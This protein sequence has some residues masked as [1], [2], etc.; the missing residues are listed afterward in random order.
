MCAALT[1]ISEVL[2]LS[3][4]VG[5]SFL[6][7][8]KDQIVSFWPHTWVPCC[9]VTQSCLTLCNPMAC[10]MPGFCVLHH[11][12]EF[13][14]THIYWVNDAIQLS[15]PV[16][17]PSSPALN[18]SQHPGLFQWVGIRWPKYWSFSFSISPSKGYSVLIFFRIDWFDL[19][20]VQ[21]W[22]H[23]AY[24]AFLF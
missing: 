4:C 22:K 19:L 3:T 21:G 12:P 18:L 7:V 23:F 5:E 10:S 6:Y 2:W 14:Q 11:L 9:S 24:F 1:N 13:A 17:P 20:A 8:F 16:S 15:H